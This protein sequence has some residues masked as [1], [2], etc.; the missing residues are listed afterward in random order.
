MLGAGAK[1]GYQT[2]P[3]D[4]L[5]VR[6]ED[7]CLQRD[8]SEFALEA[9][10]LSPDTKSKAVLEKDLRTRIAT[11]PDD[12]QSWYLLSCVL[13]S[14]A[15]YD[16]AEA[17]LRRAIELNPHP[18]HFQKKLASLLEVR[19]KNKE[20]LTDLG[21]SGLLSGFKLKRGHVQDLEAT[22]RANMLFTDR[23]SKDFGEKT[24]QK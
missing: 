12:A 5:V 16:E 18:P 1:Y 8:H 10:N 3:V 9:A 13:E 4:L 2:D 15:K 6:R 11:F 20:S 19:G 14:D 7:I 21:D 24:R 17:A 23:V 22:T